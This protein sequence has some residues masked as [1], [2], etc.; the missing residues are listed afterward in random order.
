MRFALLCNQLHPGSYDF[1]GVHF[2][3]CKITR[4]ALGQILMEFSGNVDYGTTNKTFD[5]G[6]NPDHPQDPGILIK[7]F[8]L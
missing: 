4:K 8:F 2:L 7:D 6:G 1:G 3:V 5:F